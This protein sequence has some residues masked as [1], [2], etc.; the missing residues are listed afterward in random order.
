MTDLAPAAVNQL[1][2][3][4]GEALERATAALG[5]ADLLAGPVD[6]QGSA[7]ELA[8]SERVAWV[9]LPLG[10]TADLLFVVAP[11]LADALGVPEPQSL[12]AALAPAIA[13]ICEAMGVQAGEPVVADDA[14][15]F[16]PAL[17][18]GVDPAGRRLYGAGL[19]YGE[20]HVATIAISGPDTGLAETGS[21]FD[22]VM[23]QAASSPAVT[24]TQSAA[25]AT[26]SS[27]SLLRD[28]EM[29]VTAELGRSKMTVGELLSLAPGSIIE[30]DRAAGSPIDLLVNGTLIARGEVVVVDE[31][32]GVRL[33]EIVGEEQQG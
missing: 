23:D 22:S 32:F 8:P 29:S 15:T 6:E 3:Q 2:E 24:P 14:A 12:P 16:D 4:L 19:F 27:L 11:E 20:G 30:L 13:V 7:A 31:E 25:A 26:L 18:F 33:T 9:H 10:G 21:T 1:A 17:G 5:L 28:V